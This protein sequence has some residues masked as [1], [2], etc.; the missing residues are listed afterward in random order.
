MSSQANSA[1][2]KN[3][4]VYF[5]SDGLRVSGQFTRAL[6]AAPEPA[7]L[8]SCACTATLEEKMSTCQP[9]FES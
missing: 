3:E 2:P 8:P 4:P 6:G 7:A 1:E 5:Y 9:M